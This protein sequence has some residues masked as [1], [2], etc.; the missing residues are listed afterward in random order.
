[1]PG[2][3]FGELSVA[4]AVG[5]ASSA[6]AS[7]LIFIFRTRY[8][9]RRAINFVVGQEVKRRLSAANGDAGLYEKDPYTIVRGQW[10]YALRDLGSSTPSV[11]WN[12]IE[13]LRAM[14]DTLKEEEKRV[15]YEALRLRHATSP[16]RDA[17]MLFVGAM[18][19]LRPGN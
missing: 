11:M 5:V 1:M 7:L 18:A 3:R 8:V 16:H 9:I 12:A 10:A 13:S 2:S 19:R 15:A 17:D 6:T 4:Y 14:A